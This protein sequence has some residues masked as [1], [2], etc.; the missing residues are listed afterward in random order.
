MKIAIIGC[1][2]M[3]SIYAARLAD[4]GNEVLVVGR[5]AHLDAIANGG[6]RVEG[7]S[8]TRT[9]TVRAFSEV[10]EEAVDL[11]V[12]SV[13]ALQMDG[14]VGD[15]SRVIGPRSLVLALQNG[16]GSAES[17]ARHVDSDR[18]IVGIAGGF[19]AVIRRPGH[20]FHNGMSIIRM[21]PYAGG[22]MKDVQA[23]AD[24]WRIAGFK[25]EAVANVI[26][27]QWEK[28]ICNVAYSAPCALTGLT[29]G[30]MMNDPDMSPVSRAAATEAWAVAKALGVG[31][32]VEDPIQHARDFAAS[33]PNALP[34]MLQ[35]HLNRRRSEIDVINGAVPRSAAKIGMQAPVN[36]ILVAL[37]KQKERSF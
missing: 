24:V 16:I 11:A 29:V 26:A 17:I 1:G 36:Q 23:V 34:S 21:G 9:V 8:W 4:A 12:V 2:A 7:P 10:P 33:M 13:K 25:V 6:L 37:V 28:L 14:V 35:D 22:E 5:G 27:M 3:G 18:I 32:S 15:L 30:E 19:G 31:I 20:V